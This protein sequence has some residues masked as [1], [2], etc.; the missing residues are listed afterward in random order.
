MLM[1]TTAGRA[2]TPPARTGV[3]NNGKPIPV[4]PLTM[5]ANASDPIHSPRS[6]RLI[7]GAIGSPRGGGHDGDAGDLF[8]TDLRHV[9]HFETLSQPLEGLIVGRERL[10]LAGQRG[11]PG[12]D[13]AL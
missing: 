11:R 1:I 5:P 6:Q 2:P 4:T 9:E 7:G 8:V 13:G 12:H 3:A 10:A